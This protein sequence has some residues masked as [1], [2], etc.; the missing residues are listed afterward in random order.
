V[1]RLLRPRNNRW[2]WRKRLK[3]PLSSLGNCATWK[4]I[5]KRR[6]V[7]RHEVHR[8]NKKVALEE[9]EEERAILFEVVLA[10]QDAIEA[11]KQ[12]VN[13][14][15]EEKGNLKKRSKRKERR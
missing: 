12:Q 6:D 3:K 11:A 4:K 5:E 9:E 7:H 2:S 13:D 10:K 15:A 1:Y 14:E 8:K